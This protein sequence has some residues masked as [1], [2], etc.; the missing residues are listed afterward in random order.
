M[1]LS[2][3]KKVMKEDASICLVQD[4]QDGQW[5]GSKKVLYRAQDIPE[6]DERSMAAILDMTIN[7]MKEKFSFTEMETFW[8]GVVVADAVQ[9]EKRL[10]CYGFEI[11]GNKV[12]KTSR[13]AIHISKSVMKAF[14]DVEIFERWLEGRDGSY[15]VAKHGFSVVGLIAGWGVFDAETVEEIGS[16]YAVEQMRISA[17]GEP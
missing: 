8:D 13:G 14:G 2:K 4:K 1:K 5:I 6:L 16:L 3:I 7:E 12:F 9:V 17:E 15:F 11:D 10:D